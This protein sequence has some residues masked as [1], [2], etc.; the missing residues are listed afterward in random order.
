MVPLH[1]N[2]ISSVNSGSNVVSS[3]A[4]VLTIITSF[5]L[6]FLSAS[7]FVSPTVPSLISA[8]PN[9]FIGIYTYQS[10]TPNT[11]F[12][13]ITFVS[14]STMTKPWLLSSPQVNLTIIYL[15]PTLMFFINPNRLEGFLGLF[16]FQDPS[17]TNDNNP[18]SP[19]IADPFNET[20]PAPDVYFFIC[21]YED[22]Q[23]SLCCSPDNFS[24]M[25][26]SP[27]K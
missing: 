7:A 18:S 20:S 2:S 12:K 22:S 27:L 5:I 17:I 9:L 24:F 4:L 16:Q 8:S 10:S 19:P 26:P 23:S 15:W 21:H 11:K 3:L 13:L 14:Q 25:A 6:A 1:T